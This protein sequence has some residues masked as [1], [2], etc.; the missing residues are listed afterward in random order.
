MHRKRSLPSQLIVHDQKVTVDASNA[1]VL[2]VVKCAK[3]LLGA[4][5]GVYL[6]ALRRSSGV[7]QSRCNGT[8]GSGGYEIVESVTAK[9][10]IAGTCRETLCSFEPVPFAPCTPLC[11]RGV[12]QVTSSNVMFGL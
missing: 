8:P 11:G 3:M 5:G 1:V 12:S 9:E 10:F 7:L 6:Q 2:V 4:D